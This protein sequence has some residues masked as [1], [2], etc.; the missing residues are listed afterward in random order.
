MKGPE[1]LAEFIGTAFLLIVVVGSGIMGEKLASGNMAIALLANAI[2]TGCGLFVLIHIFGPI[3]DAH[4]NPIVTTW[5]RIKNQISSK[6]WFGYVASQ[7]AGGIA[8][9]WL[10]HFIFEST[11]L[12]ISE[13]QRNGVA[14]WTSEALA[15]LGLLLTIGSFSKHQPAKVAT[16]V[17][18]Y[19]TGAY[20]FTASTSFANPAVTISRMFT[21][22]FA[23]IAPESAPGFI[24]GQASGLVI[25]LALWKVL[26]KQQT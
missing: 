20:W 6:D 21:N 3:S 19:I 2:A 14:Q 18:L 26:D 16:G 15:T 8:G 10:I 25:F 12:Q 24:A 22:T 13:H 1:F 23:G 9:V 17:A 7:L 11:V 4:F 5:C